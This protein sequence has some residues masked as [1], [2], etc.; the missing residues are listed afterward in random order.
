M[1][2]G[3]L[4]GTTLK[5]ATK[6]GR[7]DEAITARHILKGGKVDG[8]N[9]QGEDA[10][11]APVTNWLTGEARDTL[12]QHNED[13]RIRYVVKSYQTAIGWLVEENG[14]NVWYLVD[15]KM[16]PSTGSHMRYLRDVAKASCLP[17]VY[18]KNN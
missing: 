14:E 12:D 18:V 13:R 11:Y 7:T 17:V 8:T 16:S 4:V 6:V 5:I 10:N 9:F 2:N 1:K 3:T 15:G